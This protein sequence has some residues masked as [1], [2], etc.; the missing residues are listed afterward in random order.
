MN[1][2]S[3]VLNYIVVMKNQKLFFPSLAFTIMI[4]TNL[5][6]I[7][8]TWVSGSRNWNDPVEILFGGVSIVRDYDFDCL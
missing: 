6:V 2:N 1:L 7:D 5:K 8:Y 3:S 4:F